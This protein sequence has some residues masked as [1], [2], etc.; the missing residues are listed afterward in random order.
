MKHVGTKEIRTQRLL[1]RRFR[2][3]DA[4]AMYRNY[5][6]DA[7]VSRFVTWPT[8]TSQEMTDGYLTWL[9]GEY[10]KENA[11][12]WAI[13]FEGEIIGAIDLVRQDERN[14]VCEIGYCIGSRWWNRGIVTEALKAVIGYLFRETEYHCVTAC[15]DTQNPASGRV[16]EKAGMREEGVLRARKKRADGTYSDLRY[17]SILR[18]ECEL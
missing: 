14:E 16:M 18:E 10:E 1:L 17:H 8:H 2:E 6:S 7:L 3:G 11:Y 4:P 9:L 15:H 5:T 13:E 12:R